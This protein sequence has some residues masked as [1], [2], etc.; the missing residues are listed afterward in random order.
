MG[1]ACWFCYWG[2][3]KPIADIFDAAV[4]Q[5]GF[6]EA[7]TYGR[8]HIV[9]ADEN[10]DDRSIQ[11]CLNLKDS[12]LGNYQEYDAIVI[13]SLK[14]LLEVPEYMRLEPED[15]DDENPQDFPPAFEVVKR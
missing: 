10:F 8:G 12:D 13:D 5:A 6:E 7:L 2:W 1:G 9:W 14:K 3:A 4:A 15:Y 11:F